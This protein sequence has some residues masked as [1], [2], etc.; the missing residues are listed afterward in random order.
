MFILCNFSFAIHSTGVCIVDSLLLFFQKVIYSGSRCQLEN[1]PLISIHSNGVR[2]VD[3]L[4]PFFPKGRVFAEPLSAGE[5][6]LLMRYK[7]QRFE[8]YFLVYYRPL[9]VWDKVS[10]AFGRTLETCLQILIFFVPKCSRNCM[11]WRT[12]GKIKITEHSGRLA[13]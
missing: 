8:F 11:I 2:I 10:H 4:L 6:S 5:T 13:R 12:T 9:S 3:F 1:R 7:S